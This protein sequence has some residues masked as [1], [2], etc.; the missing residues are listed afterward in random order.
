M[1]P[2]KAARGEVTFSREE[3]INDCPEP[4]G[5]PDNLYINSIIQIEQVVFKDI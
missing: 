4:N 5:I 3:Y 1:S 2:R